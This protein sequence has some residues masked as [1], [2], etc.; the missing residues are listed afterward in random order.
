MTDIQC[1]K[2]GWNNKPLRPLDAA[3]FSS[4]SSNGSSHNIVLNGS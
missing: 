1:F 4:I 3:N 2:I